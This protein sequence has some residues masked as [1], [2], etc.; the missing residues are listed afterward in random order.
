MS[1]PL[2]SSYDIPI[3]GGHFEALTVSAIAFV[4][5]EDPVLWMPK[6]R[7]WVAPELSC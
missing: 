4:D 3:V 1:V 6:G 7:I 5:I 2:A